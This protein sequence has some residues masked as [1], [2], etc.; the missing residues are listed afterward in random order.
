VP[1]PFCWIAAIVKP[2]LKVK[3]HYHF[4]SNPLDVISS[5]RSS[6]LIKA[7][8]KAVF[9]PEYYATTLAAAFN[10][11][12][13]LG[14]SGSKKL[15]F[16]LKNK[17]KILYE[18][19]YRKG[20]SSTRSESYLGSEDKVRFLYV[21]RLVSGKGLEELIDSVELLRK[22]VDFQFSFTIVGDGELK[23][24][25]EKLVMDYRLNDFIEFTGAVKFGN[26]LDS[27]YSSHDV[28][29]SPS[30]SETGPRSVL[31]AASNYLYIVATDVGYTREIFCSENECECSIVNPGS[32]EGLLESYKFVINNLLKCK[33]RAERAAIISERYSLD[34]FVVKVLENAKE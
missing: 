34:D 31:E 15:P 32:V 12:S 16:F 17:V 2:Y 1:E 19:S 20:F 14:M 27:I 3:I 18:A 22:Q 9:A 21:G 25:L 24:K 23:S 13:C 5:H 7:L 30:F 4:A 29:V 33:G 28:L 10:S 11:V 8:K 26:E 6:I